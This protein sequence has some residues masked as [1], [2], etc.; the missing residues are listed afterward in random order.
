MAGADGGIVSDD[1]IDMVFN[2]KRADDRKEW[3]EHYDRSAHLDTSSSSI[4]YEE[5]IS[6]QKILPSSTRLTKRKEIIRLFL[7]NR[8]VL[9]SSFAL[10]V[11]L[12]CNY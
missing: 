10:L 6:L 3:L 4:H 2:K 1:A 7:S 12:F 8:D 11:F 9:I 5:L